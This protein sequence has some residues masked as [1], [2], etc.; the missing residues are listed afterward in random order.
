M[1]NFNDQVA[2]I[3]G[4]G[5]GIG[6]ELARTLGLE[7]AFVYLLDADES[8]LNESCHELKALPI[9]FEK[10]IVETTNEFALAKVFNA[11]KERHGKVDILVNNDEMISDERLEKMSIDDWAHLA[12]VHLKG[13]FLCSKYAQELMVANSYGRIINLSLASS[14]ENE[15]QANYATTK[16]GV[17]WFT[18]KFALE[19]GRNNITVNT[20]IPGFIETDAMKS[21]AEKGGVDYELLKEEKRNQIPVKRVGLP[22]DVAHA[23]CFFASK[24]ASFISGQV[25]YVAGG[26][27]I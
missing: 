13:T 11:I 22:E 24:Q 1:A 19:L 18:K 10:F 14:L 16:A 15:G 2:V 26:P 12:N 5:S 4:A 3:T 6:K 20:V 8:A 21:V 23:I 9:S 27:K 25:L 7:G 17:Q